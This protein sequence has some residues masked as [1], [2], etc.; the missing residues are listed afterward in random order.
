MRRSALH[1]SQCFDGSPVAGG[2]R[3]FEFSVEEALAKCA[4]DDADAEEAIDGSAV[5]GD[6]LL[7]VVLGK[8]QFEFFVRQFVGKEEDVHVLMVVKLSVE[9]TITET[10][11]PKSSRIVF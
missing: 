8:K 3:D 1:F 11:R 5:D 2:R 10:T 4:V 9:R 6:Q 7:V